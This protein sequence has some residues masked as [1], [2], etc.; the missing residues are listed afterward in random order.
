[1]EKAIFLQPFRIT[2]LHK[3]FPMRGRSEE[4][5]HYDSPL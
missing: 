2:L 1:M 4:E 3:D 5:G